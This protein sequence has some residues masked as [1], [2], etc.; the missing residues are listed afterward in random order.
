MPSTVGHDVVMSR[1]SHHR[2]ARRRLPAACLLAAVAAVPSLR[3]APAPAPALERPATYAG[4]LPCA[5]CPGVD[6]HL[7]LWED[8]VFHLR[9]T[10]A[11]DPPTLRDDIGRWTL[12]DAGRVLVLRGGAEMPLQLAVTD[13]RTLRA[14][15]LDGSP[16]V[17]KQPL[18]LV[19]LGRLEPTPIDAFL[20]GEMR[21]FADAATF[22]ECLTGRRYPIAMEADYLALERAYSKTVASPGAP[23]YVTFD[24]SIV[25]RPKTE[26]EGAEAA[27][28]VRRF[29][30]TWP[31]HACERSR[32]DSSLVNTYWRVVSLR[33]E[34]VET[35]EHG[36][37][38]H[39]ML[40]ADGMR[41]RATAGC[42]TLSGA[43]VLDGARLEFGPAAS[44]K[45]ACPG[46]LAAAG[47]ALAAA[48]AA[49]RAWR[50]E[51]QTLELRDGAGQ[52]VALLEAVYLR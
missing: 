48:L 30:G 17:S 49:V 10:W 28:V 18:E 11:G 1:R 33:G 44:T 23:L 34:R 45:M 37:E 9:R 5:D 31:G 32:A 50:V 4:T 39:V 25:D 52:E 20:G 2:R 38:A 29:V 7:D 8:G 46:P 47:E 40:A 12:E 26:G 42:N 21:Y 19:S 24:G 6:W 22:V 43:Y 16:I 51:G 3:A 15:G 27:V 41:Y 14:L 36:R 13:P 35:P